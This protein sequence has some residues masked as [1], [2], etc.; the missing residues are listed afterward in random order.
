M[1]SATAGMIGVTAL[2]AAV[3][4]IAVLIGYIAVRRRREGDGGSMQAEALIRALTGSADARSRFCDAA[5]TVAHADAVLLFGE[6]LV[7]RLTLT[8][9]SGTARRDVDLIAYRHDGPTLDAYLTGEP[10]FVA[11]LP[12][13]A[14]QEI[15]V[16]LTQAHS[17][18][19]QPVIRRRRVVGVLAVGWTR[20]IKRL[21][22]STAALVAVIAGE[23]ARAT[24]RA[25]LLHRLTRL[26]HSDPLTGLANRR[27]WEEQLESAQDRARAYGEP[28]T[29]ALLDVVAS[30][31]TTTRTAI[32]PATSSSHGSPPRGGTRCVSRTCSRAW[33]VTS[34]PPCCPTATPTKPRR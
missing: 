18:L 22:P 9:S 8:A 27:A 21:D 34:S 16:S 32:R 24:E 31:S 26:A 12:V 10:R 20:A 1:T 6:D 33:E 15:L 25:D 30:S 13:S 19:A 5:A 17:M 4:V 7:G 2:V 29:V 11:D 3:V 14:A 23:A 28:L